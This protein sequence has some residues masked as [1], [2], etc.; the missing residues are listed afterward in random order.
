MRKHEDIAML[1]QELKGKSFTPLILDVVNEVT[2]LNSFEIIKSKIDSKAI[3]PL[4]A[5]VNNAGVTFYAP[6]EL[7]ETKMLTSG[8]DVNVFGVVRMCKAFL[9][10]LRQTADKFGDARIVN[11][12][13]LFE[14]ISL[15]SHGICTYL[16]QCPI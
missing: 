5:L 11:I 4:Y 9:P 16:K 1:Q 12:S 14:Y 13:S 2:I 3:P 6:L 7:A 8:F 10:L 15:P